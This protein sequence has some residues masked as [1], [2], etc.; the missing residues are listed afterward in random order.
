MQKLGCCPWAFAAARRSEVVVK[1]K[2][3]EKNVWTWGRV[4]SFSCRKPTL[5]EP[6]LES[7][8]VM[9]LAYLADM[10]EQLNSLNESLQGEHT[11]LITVADEI[12]AFCIKLQ[13]SMSHVKTGDYSSFKRL[14]SI[15]RVSYYVCYKD[16]PKHS[17]SSPSQ[18]H[19]WYLKC[20]MDRLS[21]LC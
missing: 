19:Y 11:T 7:S 6:F 16:S 17:S 9:R 20:R 12:Q 14:C 18:L 8:F 1:G 5:V 4:G 2:C 10:L 15:E 3:L 13:C 21:F